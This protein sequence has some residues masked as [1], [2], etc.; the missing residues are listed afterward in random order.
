MIRLLLMLSLCWLLGASPAFA[1]TQPE[2]TASNGA[3]PT[4]GA[5]VPPAAGGNGAPGEYWVLVDTSAYRLDVFNGDQ[6][7]LSFEDIAVG[8]GGAA[9]E[10]ERGDKR[11]PLGEFRVLWVNMESQFHR[12]LG[13]NYPTYMHTRRGL[14][15]GLVTL[16]EYADLAAAYRAGRIPSQTTRL[17]GYL[18]IHGLGRVDPTLHRNINWTRGC[19]ALTNEEVDQLLEYVRV[20]TRVVVR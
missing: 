7:V 12:F 10:R 3:A 16:D 17:G 6:A 2:Q 19:I 20:G 5:V 15:R 8:R 18:G 1:E 13:F 9:A 4:S 11:T 14:E